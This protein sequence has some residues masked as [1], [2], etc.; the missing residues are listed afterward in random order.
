MTGFVTSGVMSDR[1]AAWVIFIAVW[2]HGLMT[3]LFVA[4]LF[5]LC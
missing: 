1:T 4:K 5:G 2:V 3:G